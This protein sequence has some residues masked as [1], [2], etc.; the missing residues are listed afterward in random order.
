MTTTTQTP[1]LDSPYPLDDALVDAYRATGHVVVPGLAGAA[2]VAAYRPVISAATMRYTTEK[3]ALADRDTYGRAFLQVTNLWRRDPE[4]AR[5]VLARRFAGVAA[6]LLGVER[7]RLYHD[8]ALYKEAGGGRT[9]WHQ[10]SL[11]W[12][13]DTDLTVTM[14]MPLVDVTPETGGLEFAD[15]SHTG[16]ALSDVAISDAADEHFG[17]VIAERGF[18]VT[19]TGPLTAGDASFHAGWTVH[20]AL[21]N[22]SAAVREVMTVIWVADGVPVAEPRNADQAADLACWLPGHAP[23]DPVDGEFNPLLP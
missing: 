14:W 17:R 16:R 7:V 19:G 9:P 10:D 18:R 8:Q 11:Y 4:V 20:R 23:G 3:R 22:R 6:R 21:P 1:T 2:E 15:G 5:F 13:F 12:P